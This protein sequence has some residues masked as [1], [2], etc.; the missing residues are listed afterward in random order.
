[1]NWNPHLLWRT[2]GIGL[3]ELTPQHRR[4]GYVHCLTP[5]GGQSSLGLL[6]DVP[7]ALEVPTDHCV[8]DMLE[9]VVKMG[10][11]PISIELFLYGV[12]RVFFTKDY[13]P[14]VAH[15]YGL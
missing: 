9:Q 6:A 13:W 4:H 8:R 10:F 3:F 15:R 11:V 14:D 7:Q 5:E 1:M 12:H 2:T